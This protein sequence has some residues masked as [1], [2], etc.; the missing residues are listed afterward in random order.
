MEMAGAFNKFY[1][2]VPVIGSEKELFRLLL[3]EKSR[4]NNQKLP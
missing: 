3:V 2:S 4:I 1:K